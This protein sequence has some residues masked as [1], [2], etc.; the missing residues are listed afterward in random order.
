VAYYRNM[1]RHCEAVLDGSEPPKVLGIPRSKTLGEALG[2]PSGTDPRLARLYLVYLSRG[3]PFGEIGTELRDQRDERDRKEWTE[4]RRR[5]VIRY[6]ADR[7]KGQPSPFQVVDFVAGYQKR[8]GK[9]YGAGV[10]AAGH[11]EKSPSLISKLLEVADEWR[12]VLETARLYFLA[13]LES[14][15]V[16]ENELRA[17][18]SIVARTNRLL[19]RLPRR[20]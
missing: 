3:A 6:N 17:L 15:G 18:P 2:F 7:A 16:D 12:E 14:G 5:Q 10:A 4:S 9:W 1:L 13:R 19:R 8:E 20:E 11:F